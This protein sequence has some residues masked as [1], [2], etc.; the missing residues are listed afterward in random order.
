[1]MYRI[2]GI[3]GDSLILICNKRFDIIVF[4]LLVLIT[5]IVLKG[6]IKQIIE[7]EITG[8]ALHM[9]D[10]NIRQH[11]LYIKK[12]LLGIILLFRLLVKLRRL[13]LLPIRV[14]GQLGELV[15][16]VFQES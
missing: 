6:D 3:P 4:P 13:T 2:D 8:F 10:L 11:L 14:F 15:D 12:V 1:M 5:L 16:D 7:I 9:H